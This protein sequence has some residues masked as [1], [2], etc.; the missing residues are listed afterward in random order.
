M[1][2]FYPGMTVSL[3]R[4]LLSGNEIRGSVF[5]AFGLG[6]GP[7]ENKELLEF[8]KNKSDE[9]IVLVDASQCY[10][11]RVDMGSYETGTVLK[12]VGCVSAVDMTP[13][14]AFV[15]LI[16][17]FVIFL[18]LLLF[19]YLFIYSVLFFLRFEKYGKPA[20]N[21]DSEGRREMLELI[22]KYMEINIRGELSEQQVVHSDH[23]YDI[24]EER[25]GE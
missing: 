10:K 17:L 5:L 14:T 11:G 18:L 4:T 7:S 23:V 2:Y 1:V 13:A 24:G 6:N 3:F 19:I 25:E 22:K 8:L 9:G 21:S 16:Y 15:K 12:K 20:Y